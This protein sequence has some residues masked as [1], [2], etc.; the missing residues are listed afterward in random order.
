MVTLPQWMSEFHGH[1]SSFMPI[2]LGHP[3]GCMQNGKKSVSPVLNEREKLSSIN[4][5]SNSRF[6]MNY[7]N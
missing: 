6:L 5:K 1:R 7:P 3:Q 2:G 4:P